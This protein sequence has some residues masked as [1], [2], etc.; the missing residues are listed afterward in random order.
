MGA[1]AG[2]V[3]SVFGLGS[4]SD[5][6]HKVLDQLEAIGVHETSK[7]TQAV[8]YMSIIIL[9]TNSLVVL[10]GLREKFRTRF[11]ACGHAQG[12]GACCVK[13]L[14]KVLVHVKVGLSVVSSVAMALLFE[15]VALLLGT[16]K[17]ACDAS[18]DGAS[19]ILDALDLDSSQTLA[20]IT[21]VCDAL[22][23]GRDGILKC[24]IGAL[25]LLFAQIIIFGYW[26]KYTTLA[27]ADPFYRDTEDGG[28]GGG[29][30]GGGK[31]VEARVVNDPCTSELAPVADP[32]NGQISRF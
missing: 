26:M 18:E 30:G 17:L 28:S 19:A 10:Y 9:A 15:A 3:G 16:L 27:L 23:D 21:Q 11:D 22:G 6:A 31:L 1:V 12:A 32:Y 7:V 4:I 13:F 20:P 2:L 5:G 8:V 29:G 25:V 24:F 14:F